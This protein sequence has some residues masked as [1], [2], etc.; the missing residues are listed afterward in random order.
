MHWFISFQLNENL[1]QDVLFKVFSDNNNI[2]IWIILSITIYITDWV[3]HEFNSRFCVTSWLIS[4]R[5]VGWSQT[6]PVCRCS[7][8]WWPRPV[9]PV[10]SSPASSRLK[11]AFPNQQS[12]TQKARWRKDKPKRCARSSAASACSHVVMSCPLWEAVKNNRLILPP[13][14]RAHRN[15]LPSFN[16]SVKLHW[17]GQKKKKR[18]TNYKRDKDKRTLI[19]G[20]K[21]DLFFFFYFVFP[22][23][24]NFAVNPARRFW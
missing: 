3:W 5:Q 4:P 10:P 6:S 15:A 21:C 12:F 22:T 8:D 9:S 23:K 16:R 19:A 18:K 20:T 7:T 24:P 11:T 2:I 13:R 1:D 17:M 14:P